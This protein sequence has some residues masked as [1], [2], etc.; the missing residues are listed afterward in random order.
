MKLVILPTATEKSLYLQSMVE[1]FL[2][3]AIWVQ[4]DADQN[5][6]FEKISLDAK[7]QSIKDCGDFLDALDYKVKDIDSV[8]MGHDFFLT[9]NRHGAGFWD[10]GNGEFGDELTQLSHKFSEFTPVIGDDGLVYFE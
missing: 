5:I 9:R 4:F 10:R 3:T 7:I 1:S 8:Q 6:T 2:N